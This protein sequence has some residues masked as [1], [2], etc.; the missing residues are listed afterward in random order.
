MRSGYTIL[1]K[2]VAV[3]ISVL[4]KQLIGPVELLI[5]IIALLLAYC[6]VRVLLNILKRYCIS[7]VQQSPS[8][9]SHLS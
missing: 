8:S 7:Q 3:I 1:V 5:I 9:L 6:P 2:S 4:N